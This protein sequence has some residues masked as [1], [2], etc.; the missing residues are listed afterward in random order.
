MLNDFHHLHKKKTHF[1][2]DFFLGLPGVFGIC[3]E[4]LFIFMELGSTGNY[5]REPCPKVKTKF[6]NLT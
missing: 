5:F 3:G 2:R 6:K 4:G 1:T